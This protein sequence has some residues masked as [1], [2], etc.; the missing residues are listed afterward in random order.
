MKLRAMAKINLG[1]DVLGRRS[2]GYHEVRMIM[3]TVTMFDTLEILEKDAPGISLS[4]N[5]PYVPTDDRNLVFRAASLLMEEAG[6]QTDAFFS[7][8]SYL[9]IVRRGTDKGRA[10]RQ[11]C[12]LLHIAPE[13][14]YAAG[15]AANDIPMLEAAHAGFAIH[16]ASEEV[17]LRADHTTVRDNNHDAVAEIIEN[18]IL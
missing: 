7:S 5:L 15:D 11:M 10:L 13:N 9:E 18:W 8:T 12:E 14:T 6:D 3:Q 17:C 4:T 16:G 1:L 2:D